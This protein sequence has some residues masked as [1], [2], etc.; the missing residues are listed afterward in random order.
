MKSTKINDCE[1]EIIDPVTGGK[2]RVIAP[3]AL[4]EAGALF[5]ITQRIVEEDIRPGKGTTT[6]VLFQIRIAKEGEKPSQIFWKTE[7]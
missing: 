5:A 7:N 1:Y 6:T 2:W 3:H 4:S